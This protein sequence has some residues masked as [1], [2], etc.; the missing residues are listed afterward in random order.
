MNWN[1]LVE[2]VRRL[3]PMTEEER[4]EQRISFAYGNVAFHN[5][6]ITREMVEQEVDRLDQLTTSTRAATSTASDEA[7]EG[8][9]GN[10]GPGTP[11]AGTRRPSEEDE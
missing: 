2:A 5:P 7:S 11:P 8:P 4:R 1:E 9:S 6:A 10:P 3:P